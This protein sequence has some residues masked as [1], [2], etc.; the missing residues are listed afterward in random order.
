M[1]EIFQE[2]KVEEEYILTTLKTLKEALERKEIGIIELTAVAAFIQNIYNG[3]ENI[4][5]RVLKHKKISFDP[6]GSWH[7]D[8]LDIAVEHQIISSELSTRLDEYRAFRHFF[9]H[10]YGIMLEEAQLM[11]LAHH[12]PALWKDFELELKELLIRKKFRKEIKEKGKYKS[13]K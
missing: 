3:I 6:S 8:L 4:L 7:K 10:G 5:K 1:D 11:P 9:V 12:L 2:I 13:M